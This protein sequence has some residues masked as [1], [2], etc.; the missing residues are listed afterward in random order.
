MISSNCPTRPARLAAA[1]LSLLLLGSPAAH[2]LITEPETLVYGRILNRL[3]PN[4]DHLV[5]AGELRWTIQQTD[6][7]TIQLSGEVD[8]FD[9]GNYS[10]L[11]RIP[12]QAMMLGQTPSS[13]TLPLGTVAATASHIA[14]TLDG[15]PA[16]IMAPA[17]SVLDLDQLLRASALRL[18]L[19]INVPTLDGD[20]DGIPD[21]WEDEHGLDKQNAND[22]LTDLNGNGLNNLGE[23]LAGTDPDRDPTVP[24]LLTGEF[25]S[26]ADAT[27]LVLLETA[28][29]DSTPAQLVYTLHTAPSG[30]VL[31]LRNAYPLPATTSRVLAPGAIFTQADV[32]AGRLVFEHAA[33]ETPAS[34]EVGVRDENPGHPE[35]RGSVLPRV[36]EPAEGMAAADAEESIRLEALR[37]ATDHGHLVADLGATAGKHRLSAPSAGLSATAYQTHA[38]TY[39]ADA[40]HVFLGGPSDDTF[41]GGHADDFFHGGL[42]SNTLSGGRGGDSFLFTGTSAKEEKITDFSQSEGDVIDLTG[43]LNGSSTLLTD[44][45][46]IVRSGADALLQISATGANSG[47]GDRTVRL[48]NS[49]LQPSDLLGLYYGGNL[50]TGD[51][52]LPPRLSIAATAPLASENGPADGLF[53]ITREGDLTEPLLVNLQITGNATNGVDYQN[54]SPALWIPA[55]QIAATVAIR[56]YVDALVE[57]NEVV[58][59][60]LGASANYLLGSA[61]TA[62][63]AIEDLKPQI[64][65]EVIDALAG[66]SDLSPGALLV[67]RGGLLSPEVFV[68]FTLSG[69]A[70]NGTDYNRITPYFTFASG[71]TTRVIEFIPKPGVNF[72]AAEAKKIRMTVKADPAYASLVPAAELMIVPEELSYDSWLAANG[73]APGSESDELRM[74]YAFS[75]NPQLA[76]DPSMLARQ[77]KATLENGYLTLRFRRKPGIG[78]MQYQVEYSNDLQQWFNGPGVVEDITSQVAPNDAGAAVFRATK[79]MSQAQAAS[80]RVRLLPGSEANN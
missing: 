4:L 23:Y 40:P 1:W 68:Q 63:V 55:G 48:Q 62:Q 39:G 27:S 46:R 71:Q 70:V 8:S 69:T 67:R 24:Q 53:T 77:P 35:D 47:F 11:I 57:F 6:G 74:R 3:N 76:F 75:L 44:Y 36:F 58:Y 79:P 61:F 78:D 51:V 18:D 15:A 73:F 50:E 59:L 12:H 41:T 30:G 54:L 42:G 10:Y 19:E 7:S 49:T 14:I 20:G 66:V 21:W 13:L 72:G 16:G 26:Y 2:A 22:A 25:I 31:K 5:T 38:T 9:D 56:P 28:D 52:G 65:L 45:V 32:L 37:L 60:E 43:V 64:S 80:M 33:G 34:F 17:T 29:S